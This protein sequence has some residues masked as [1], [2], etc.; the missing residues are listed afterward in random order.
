MSEEVFGLVLDVQRCDRPMLPPACL[1]LL[2]VIVEK[3][4]WVGVTV[5]LCLT[6]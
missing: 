1:A 3:F 4:G 6:R 5:K 2:I